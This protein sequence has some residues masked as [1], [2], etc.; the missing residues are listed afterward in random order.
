MNWFLIALI[1]P[2]LWSMSAQVDKFIVSKYF[3]S[4]GTGAAVMLIAIV[5]TL[6]LPFI[7]IV[8]PQV[9]NAPILSIFILVLAGICYVI[10][11]VFYFTALQ[12]EDASIVVSLLQLAPVFSYV[13]GFMFLHEYL[14]WVQIIAG[15]VIITGSVGLT[16]EFEHKITIKRRV[17]IL[18]TSCAFF[19]ALNSFLFKFV[20]ETTSFGTGLFWQYIGFTLSGIFIFICVK[21]YR[22]EIL[23]LFKENKPK[24][25]AISG[26]NELVNVAG[27]AALSFASLIAPLALVWLANSFEPFFTFLIGIF[28]TIFFPNFIKEN[29]SK[30]TLLQKSIF[31][32]LIILGTILIN[33]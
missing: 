20:A 16:L 26:A 6:L 11:Y 25:L 12:N 23:K 29:I 31:I 3:K 10:T 9:V 15:L 1:T 14:T 2:I 18:M 19:A 4:G 32:I 28:F 5:D 7:F 21:N 30:K 24:V 17:F 33:K 13:L 22:Q 27:N 8:E